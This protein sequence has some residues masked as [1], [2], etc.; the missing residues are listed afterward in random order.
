MVRWSSGAYSQGSSPAAVTSVESLSVHVHKLTTHRQVAQLS[1]SDLT[2]TLHFNLTLMRLTKI[3]MFLRK[4]DACY[5]GISKKQP[6]IIILAKFYWILMFIQIGSCHPLSSLP[7][8]PR[9]CLPFN[10]RALVLN[11][12]IF[13]SEAHLAPGSCRY[14]QLLIVR[15]P[16]HLIT[17][18]TPDN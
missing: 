9:L 15:Q 3:F 8:S 12:F 10:A 4:K 7:N 13:R 5:I 6:P 18:D 2:L 1:A 11:D 16:S 14:S 17:N